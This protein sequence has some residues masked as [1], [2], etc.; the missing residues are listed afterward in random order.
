MRSYLHSWQLV[1]VRSFD[2]SLDHPDELAR[3]HEIRKAKTVDFPF[4]SPQF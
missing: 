3:R 4:R 2:D 1:T